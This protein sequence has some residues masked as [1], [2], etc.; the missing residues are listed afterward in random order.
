MKVQFSYTPPPVEPV[1]ATGFMSHAVVGKH[2]PYIVVLTYSEDAA[3]RILNA[4]YDKENYEVIP[5]PNQD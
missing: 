4:F 2:N 3:K 1:V 5:V